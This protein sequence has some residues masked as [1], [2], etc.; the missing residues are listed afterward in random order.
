MTATCQ[1]PSTPRTVSRTSTTGSATART[2]GS[3]ADSAGRTTTAGE[4][5]CGPALTS[6]KWRRPSL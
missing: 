1:P 4:G 3:G 5:T 6:A 2:S